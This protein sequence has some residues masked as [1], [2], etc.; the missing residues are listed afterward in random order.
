[1]MST[2][3]DYIQASYGASTYQ[4][5]STL[6]ETKKTMAKAKNQFIFLQRCIKHK[7]IPKSLRIKSPYRSPKTK[8]ITERFRF[9]M[10]ISMKNDAKHRFFNLV[11]IVRET[12][13]KLKLVLSESDMK[14]INDTTEKSREYM[15]KRSKERLVKKFKGLQ[16]KK[17]T[18]SVHK[19]KYTKDPILNLAN[20]EIPKHHRD[21]LNL[22]P[23]FVPHVSGIPY[24]DIVSTTESSCLKLE[25]GG[26]ISEAQTLRKDVLRVLKM[27]KPVNDNMTREQRIAIK[28]IKNDNTI[29]IYPFDKGAGLVRIK[30]EDAIRKIREQIGNTKIIDEDPTQTFATKIRTILCKLNKKKRFTKQEYARIYPSDPLPPRMYGTVKAHKSEKNYPMRTVVST[31]GTANHGLSEYLVKLSQN[32]LNKNKTRLKNSQSFVKQAKNWD[33]SHDEVQVSYDVVNL[34]PSVPVKE[35][36]EVIVDLLNKDTNLKQH[37]K[38]EILEIKSLI[39]ICLSKCYFLW[40]DEIHELENSGPIGLSLM[41]VM[42]EAFLQFIESKAITE[43]LHE[44]PPIH[45]KSFL[46]F[47]DDSHAR[48][49]LMES[50]NKFLNILNRQNRNI[51][52][53]IEKEN[54]DKSLNFLDVKVMN[55]GNGKYEFNVFRKKAI[56]NVQVK[57][58]SGHDPRILDG[59]FKGF[60]H[61]AFTIC[62]KNYINEELDFLLNVFTENGYKENELKKIIE[63]VRKKFNQQLNQNVGTR[64]IKETPDDIKPTITLPWIPGVS[65]KLRKI[66]RK[67]GY[68]VAF[69]SNA[70]LQTILTSKNKVKLPKNSYPGVYKIPCTCP[71]VPPYIGETRLKICTRTDQHKAYIEKEQWSNSGCASHSRYCEGVIK[72][73]ETETVKVIYNKFDRKVREA[74]EIELNQC[75]PKQGGMNLDDGQYVKTKFWTPFLDKLRKDR[76]PN[77]NSNKPVTDNSKND[78]TTANKKRQIIYQRKGLRRQ[79]NDGRQ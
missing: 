30:R 29:D 6:K 21:L 43:A 33:I 11:K 72:F 62:S 4:L 69:K 9:D 49:P 15:F 71:K 17:I 3:K 78:R 22:G 37:T 57:P 46:R 14:V 53:T 34:Y 73:E 26:K 59:I 55:N 64:N 40:N 36:T 75:G 50:A 56:T 31:I 70:N 28:E 44:Q 42:A 76:K 19:N 10:L 16:E 52:Y 67:A 32:T 51:Q 54:D 1:M 66:Y 60:V 39:D 2:L 74:L 47:V 61:R 41:V 63:E 77:R 20:D 45:L 13:N 24:M 27:A 7:L 35:A 23:K 38:L 12:E 48:F 65:P 25:Y 18:N 5:T 68:K 58:T 79:C 8:N